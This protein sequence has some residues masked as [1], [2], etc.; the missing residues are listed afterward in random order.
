MNAAKSSYISVWLWDTDS[1]SYIQK[2]MPLI[3]QL[4][5]D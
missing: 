2:K 3:V 4:K 1:I 5:Y